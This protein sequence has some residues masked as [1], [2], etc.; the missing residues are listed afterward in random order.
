MNWKGIEVSLFWDI[1]Q[2][3]FRQLLRFLGQP[4]GPG[5]DNITFFWWIIN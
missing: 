4:F 3:L 5:T 1:M 2:H